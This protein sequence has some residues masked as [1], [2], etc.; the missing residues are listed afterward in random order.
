MKT[1]GLD[2]SR[3]RMAYHAYRNGLDMWNHP[4]VK[5]LNI[6]S[7]VP[8]DDDAAYNMGMIPELYIRWCMKLD[9]A[10]LKRKHAFNPT[11]R[12][13]PTDKK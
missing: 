1:R 10:C 3:V 4:I 2:S 7:L 9:L 6:C 11:P 13:T 8:D 5:E 12:K